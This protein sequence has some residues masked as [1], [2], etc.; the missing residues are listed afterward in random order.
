MERTK[1]KLKAKYRRQFSYNLRLTLVII[2]FVSSF[3]T[4]LYLATKSFEYQ[5]S[6]QID[7][8]ENQTTDY[9]VNLKPND[10][11]SESSLGKNMI[12]IASLIDSI[13]ISFNYDFNIEEAALIDFDYKIMADLI[14]S[15]PNGTN[16][17]FEKEYTLKDTKTTTLNHEEK[18]N[19]QEQ[20]TIDYDHYNQ[21]MTVI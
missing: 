4:T 1:L 17:Y 8:H 19:L 6:K 15:S 11:Y 12:Y 9:K 10:F 7:Y 18:L 13:D 2:V 14:I 16:N 21:L 3:L 20:V 5:N